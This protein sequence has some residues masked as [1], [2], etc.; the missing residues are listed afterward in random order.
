[1]MPLLRGPV[2][3]CQSQERKQRT[4]SHVAACRHAQRLLPLKHHAPHS[5][6]F[7]GKRPV[8]VVVVAAI[9]AVV[10]VL[11]LPTLVVAVLLLNLVV[12]V[13]VRQL[14]LAMLALSPAPVAQTRARSPAQERHH[15]WA[16][17]QKTQPYEDAS[18]AAAATG[19]QRPSL[20]GCR[21]VKGVHAM[22][23]PR[24]ALPWRVALADPPPPH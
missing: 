20:A 11:L 12:V 9:P 19:P 5:P 13:A 8:V 18:I 1:M 6:H 3:P 23:D 22:C 4:E 17:V 21:S 16:V 10:V 7:R 2:R 15:S 24:P 14:T